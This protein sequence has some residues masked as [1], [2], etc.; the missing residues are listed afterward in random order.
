MNREQCCRLWLGVVLGIGM[1]AGSGSAFAASER[2]V[3]I[4]AES[5]AEPGGWVLDTQAIEQMGSPYLMAHGL[6]RPV[7]DAVTTV[8]IPQ[9][10]RY[11][12]FVRT[13][14][15]VARWE[16]PGQP[17][18]FQVL[19]NG[20][21]LDET[22]GTQGAE[23]FW[24]DGG[25]VELEGTEV[26]VTLR[27]LTGFNGRCDAI[28]LSPDNQAPPN[29]Q[30]SLPDWRRQRLGL[31][32]TP[33]EQEPYDLVVVGGGLAGMSTAISAARMGCRV[34]L[35][36]NRP[37]LGGNN[38]DEI[39]VWARGRTRRNR[40]PRIGEIV[41]EFAAD[42]SQSPWP[43]SEVSDEPKE[44]VVRA[45]P[46]IDLFLNHHATRVQMDEA[47]QRIA[48]VVAFD[49]R[50]S[51]E[52]RFT[53][54]LFADCTGHGTIGYLAGADYEMRPEGQVGMGMSNM[55]RWDEAEQPVA[56][57]E[58]PWALDLNMGDFPY[59]QNQHGPWFW[60]GGFKKHPIRDLEAIRDGNLRAVFGAF[61]A[62][63]NREGAADHQ[64]AYL[65]WVA[66]IGGTRESRRLLGD[67][68]LSGDHI[69][70]DRQFP[71]GVV[72]TTWSI[73]LHYPREEYAEKFPERPFI[74]RAV[75]DRPPA[76]QRPE[77][78]LVPYRCFYSRNV[79]N[80]FMAGR[81][82]SVT[83]EG[84]GTVRVMQTGGMMGEVVGKAAAICVRRQIEP[85]DVYEQ[86]L[87]ELFE[88]L[89]LPGQARRATVDGP[90]KMPEVLLP[91]HFRGPFS[92]LD[93][94]KLDGIVLDTADAQREGRWT[95]GQGLPRYIGWNYLYSSADSGARIRFPFNPPHTGPYEVRLAYQAHENR[96]TAVPVTIRCGEREQTLRIDM[97]QAPPQDEAFL[98][99]GTFRFVQDQTGSI[100]I[101]TEGAGG[102]VHA[103]AV[104]FLPQEAETPEP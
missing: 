35:I 11:R 68:I 38:S 33:I 48:A 5:F 75:F 18:R 15:W 46:L 13:K 2:G 72:P 96:G 78:Y 30:A 26:T 19:L 58:T 84:L 50:T 95:V 59:P 12:V 42:G 74:A 101:G 63:K 67:V 45:E 22:F 80:L 52:K 10:G 7:A 44:A 102:V 97:R 89:R 66:Y 85:R 81:C 1:L 51:Q 16:A 43:T 3:L 103:D 83:R 53:A 93:P 9:P 27:D 65:S 86:H 92:G 77:G 100:E 25:S 49:T 87:E 28:Y 73:D 71:D 40:F 56:F 55:W 94:T 82:V 70:A 47:G 17:G 20:Q 79:P 36:Q 23:W 76:L 62:M 6:G 69:R 31:P 4:E 37:V 104:Q 99:L 88:L 8:A 39:R 91:A 29:D 24:H 61:N 60:E 21:P 41:E 64:N 34:A 54:P 32:E 98:S 57:P 14:D 90:L